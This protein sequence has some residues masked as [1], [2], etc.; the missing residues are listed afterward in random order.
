MYTILLSKLDFYLIRNLENH[1]FRSYLSNRK[2]RVFV[3]GTSSDLSPIVYGVP[4]GSIL[5]PLLFLTYLNDFY[6]ASNHFSMRMFADDTSL[7]ATGNNLDDLLERINSELPSI[8][9]W[10]C[11]NKLTLNL[12]KTKY[13]IFQPRQKINYNLHPPLILAGKY[14][15]ASVSVKY[16]GLLIDSHL[17]F[18]D[19]IDYICSNVSKNINTMAKVKPFLCKKSLVSI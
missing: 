6:Q 16:L 13:I 19:H 17:S 15:D 2:Q 14:V 1:C 18:H 8:Y 7:T 12:S 10:L 5:G 11:A 4:Q 3:N 9:D